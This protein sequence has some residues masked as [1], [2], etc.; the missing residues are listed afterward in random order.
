MCKCCEHFYLN[1][2]I[3]PNYVCEYCEGTNGD[4]VVRE[5]ETSELL[6]VTVSGDAEAY[7]LYNDYAFSKGFSIRKGKNR[8]RAGGNGW[9]MR[10]YLCSNAGVKDDSK[11]VTRGYDRVDIRTNCKAFVQF[12]I[13]KDGVWTCIRHDM[14]HNHE[15]VPLDK[16]HLLRSQ[17]K[18]TDD[19]RNL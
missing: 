19:Q 1:W 7:N 15:M 6:Y 13:G 14:V 10:R 2:L 18:I 16:R 3:Y 12:S 17:R 4:F 9:T 5:G 8:A 11:K